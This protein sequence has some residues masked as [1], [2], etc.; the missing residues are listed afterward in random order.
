MKIDIF[1]SRGLRFSRRKYKIQLPV[2]HLNRRNTSSITFEIKRF[3]TTPAG[4]LAQNGEGYQGIDRS[5]APMRRGPLEVIAMR[6]PEVTK[7][8]GWGL[9]AALLLGGLIVIGSRNLSHF[10]AALV[11]YTFAVLFA[12]FGITTGR[13]L[14][15]PPRRP[16]TRIKLE[17]R[18][19]RIYAAGLEERTS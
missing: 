8:S 10:D 16:L 5:D 7:A 17:V 19:G 9:V 3:T 11:G 15:G 13:P 2:I 4:G 18:D 12:A 6:K 1:M 14:A